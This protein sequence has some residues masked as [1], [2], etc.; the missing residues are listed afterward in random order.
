MGWGGAGLVLDQ[1]GPPPHPHVG[2]TWHKG[3]YL[4]SVRKEGVVDGCQVVMPG[5]SFTFMLTYSLAS[6]GFLIGFVVSLGN[7]KE[8]FVCSVVY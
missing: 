1:A 6:L 5:T 3:S 4:G 2:A 7:Q 8:A